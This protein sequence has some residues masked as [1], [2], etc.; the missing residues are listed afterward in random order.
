MIFLKILIIYTL[1]AVSIYI[2]RT[3]KHKVWFRWIGHTL[4]YRWHVRKFKLK[5][6]AMDVNT[7]TIALAEWLDNDF[8][9]KGFWFGRGIRK[10]VIKELEKIAK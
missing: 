7:R 2:Y 8:W 1:L 6:K 5:L 10:I 9:F 4:K 3:N